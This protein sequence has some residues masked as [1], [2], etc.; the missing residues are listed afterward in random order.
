MLGYVRHAND[1]KTIASDIVDEV[2]ALDFDILYRRHKGRTQQQDSTNGAQ[3]LRKSALNNT[4]DLLGRMYT[5]DMLAVR[6]EK[7]GQLKLVFG[8]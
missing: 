1:L 2:G 7:V 8:N 5:R 6:L 4:S 3:E